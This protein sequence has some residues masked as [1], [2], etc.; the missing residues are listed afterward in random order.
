MKQTVLALLV[1]VAGCKDSR[2]PVVD[3]AADTVAVAEVAGPPDR[4]EVLV[5]LVGGV[6]TPAYAA[7]SAEAPRLSTALTPFPADA[8]ALA[9]ARAAWRAT[10]A[11]WRRTSA[12]GV[13][14]ADDLAL[15]GGVIDEPTHAERLETLLAGSTPLDATAVRSLPANLRGLLALEHLLFDPAGDQALLARFADAPGAR[16]RLYLELV[17]RDLEAKLTAVASAWTSFGPALG[18]AGRGSTV[19]ARER[20][21]YDALMNKALAITD[22]TIDIL[23]QASGGPVVHAALPISRRSGTVAADLGDDLA[24][25]AALY[26]GGGVAPAI[27]DVV[28]DVNPDAHTAMERALADA[29]RTVAAL[30]PLDGALMTQPVVDAVAALR[31]LK[32][33]LVTGVFSALGISVGFSDNDGD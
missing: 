20:D 26:T 3:A 24:S 12:F 15:T 1:V 17:A 4:H 8:A 14:P 9:T 13:G 29:R 33:A 19:F 5:A 25:L 7:L 2:R 32:L 16:R 6:I 10:R 22:R 21:A 23:R 28:R 30:P 31:A 11:A 27:A 18:S